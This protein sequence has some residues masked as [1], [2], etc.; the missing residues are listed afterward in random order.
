MPHLPV[1]VGA[2]HR[3]TQQ[4][5][6]P[7][8][9]GVRVRVKVSVLGLGLGLGWGLGL[10]FGLGLVGVR[11]RVSEP[12]SRTVGRKRRSHGGAMALPRWTGDASKVIASGRSAAASN[13]GLGL[14]LELELGLGL[15]LGL[16]LGL[17]L[18]RRLELGHVARDTSVLVPTA[19]QVARLLLRGRVRV[20]VRVGVRVRVRDQGSG[21][22]VA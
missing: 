8:L 18:D 20:R 5:D 9:L 11:V 22:E 16:R 1:R 19:H 13:L 6:Q 15:R 2:L 7:R 4:H 10:G 3:V 14:G 17:G 21:L 12:I